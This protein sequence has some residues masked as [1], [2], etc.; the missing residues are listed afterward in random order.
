MFIEVSGFS[1]DQ[2]VLPDDLRNP[3]TNK[4][5]VVLCLIRWLEPHPDATRRD[6]QNRPVCPGPFEINHSLWRFARLRRERACFS[7]AVLNDQMHLFPGS[8][9]E[10][11]RLQSDRL[12]FARYDLVQPQTFEIFLNCTVLDEDAGTILETNTLPCNMKNLI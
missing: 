4:T 8:T 5:K 10:E 3:P 2:L 9:D 7:P 1:D 11:K 6:E 12:R